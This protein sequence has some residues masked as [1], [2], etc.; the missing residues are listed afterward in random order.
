[1]AF[2]I[3]RNKSQRYGNLTDLHSDGYIDDD[4][5]SGIKHGYKFEIVPNSLNPQYEYVVLA[6]P[7]EPD[8]S[9]N[10]Y[11]FSNQSGVIRFSRTGPENAAIGGR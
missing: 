7:V 9:G 5:G 8:V 2:Y 10:R 3:E 6:N 11:Y 1:M 4:L